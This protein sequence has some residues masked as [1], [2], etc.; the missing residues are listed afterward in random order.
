MSYLSDEAFAE[1]WNR[2]RS[3]AEVSAAAGISENYASKRAW[4]A[5]SRGVN[6]NRRGGGGKPS[7]LAAEPDGAN[8]VRCA[9]G[10][11]VLPRE[12]QEH[13]G[14][15]DQWCDDPASEWACVEC[16]ER[17]HRGQWRMHVLDW[18]DA[19]WSGDAE[20]TEDWYY[21]RPPKG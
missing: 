20:D 18:H 9:C 8:V 3:T 10:T 15:C 12:V 2:C 17:V 1:L 5:R 19:T 4:K 13:A 16:E 11:C 14:R 7:A 6:L 21:Q